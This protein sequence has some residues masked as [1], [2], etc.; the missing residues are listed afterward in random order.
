MRIT[1]KDLASR[2]NVRK[3]GNS[4]SQSNSFFK[5]KKIFLLSI[6]LKNNEADVKKLA[7]QVYTVPKCSFVVFCVEN[8]YNILAVFSQIGTDFEG[9]QIIQIL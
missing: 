8:G 3:L 2:N 6:A 9:N 7:K 5:V 1:E 4:I